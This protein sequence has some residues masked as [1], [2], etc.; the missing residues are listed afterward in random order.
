MQFY[1][2]VLSIIIERGVIANGVNFFYVSEVSLAYMSYEFLRC[3][4]ISI[5]LF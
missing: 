1:F 2:Q 3:T 4:F 5:S